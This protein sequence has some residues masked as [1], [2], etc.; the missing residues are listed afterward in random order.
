MG[1]YVHLERIRSTGYD[2][3]PDRYVR[4]VEERR[5]TVPPAKLLADIRKNQHRLLERIDGLLSRLDM[6]PIAD[7]KIPPRV[8]QEEGMTLQPFGALSKEQ[9]AVWQGVRGRVET[10]EKGEEKYP[11]P[12]PFTPAEIE[13]QEGSDPSPGTQTTLDILER[14]GLIV[15]ITIMSPEGEE[16]AM[17][18]RLV[19]ERDRWKDEP[20][21]PDQGTGEP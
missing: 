5:E 18:Y 2:L 11:T 3:R 21:K 13:L 10:W 9:E 12:V 19:S 1:M 4:Q 15:P 14:M 8:W 6:P 20:G 16:A 17:R 7:E